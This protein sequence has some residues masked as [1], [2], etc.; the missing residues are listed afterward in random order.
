MFWVWEKGDR[1][2]SDKNTGPIRPYGGGRPRE[3]TVKEIE[4]AAAV[5]LQDAADSTK[6]P[7]RPA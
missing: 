3:I 1:R 6:Q 5:R 2:L 7:P 4:R